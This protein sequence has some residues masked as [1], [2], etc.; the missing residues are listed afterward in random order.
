LVV[1]LAALYLFN[2]LWTPPQPVAVIIYVVAALVL[3]FMVLAL[4]HLMPLPFTLR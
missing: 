4:F 2:R 3:F 1:I